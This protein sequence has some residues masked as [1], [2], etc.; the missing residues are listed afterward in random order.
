MKTVELHFIVLFMDIGAV[1]QKTS[2]KK[3][4]NIPW[5]DTLE[6]EKFNNTIMIFAAL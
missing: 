6:R 1:T 5:S 3:T 2:S 4:K